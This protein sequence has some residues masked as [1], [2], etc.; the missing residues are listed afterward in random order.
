MDYLNDMLTTN[1]FLVV[2]LGMGLLIGTLIAL[3]IKHSLREMKK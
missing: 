3:G 2:K 1:W